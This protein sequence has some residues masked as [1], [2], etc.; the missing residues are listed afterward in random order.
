M[1]LISLF[2]DIQSCVYYDIGEDRVSLER[3]AKVLL[4]ESKKRHPNSQVVEDLMSRT[5]PMR[6]RDILENAYDLSTLFNKYP[7]LKDP[8]VVR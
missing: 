5:F 7:F 1:K 4:E 6:R 8:E 2:N 3:H